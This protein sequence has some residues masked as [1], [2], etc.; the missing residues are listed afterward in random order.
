MHHYL[1]LHMLIVS[2]SMRNE[3]ILLKS[4]EYTLDALSHL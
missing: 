1:I 3:D 2:T 4:E